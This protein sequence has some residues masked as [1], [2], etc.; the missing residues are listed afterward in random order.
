MFGL[1]VGRRGGG[2]RDRP[3]FRLRASQAMGPRHFELF[4]GAVVNAFTGIDDP[5]ESLESGRFGGE[6]VARSAGRG[7]LDIFYEEGVAGGLP[8]LGLDAARAAEAPLAGDERIDQEALLGVGGAVLL[9]VFGGKLGEI[10][11]F[12]VEHDLL[13]GV[14]AVLE[15]VKAGCGLTG[16]GAGSGR[17]LCVGAAG[18]ALFGSGLKHGRILDSTLAGVFG[19]AGNGRA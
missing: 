15:G 7:G 17:L 10:P 11:G 4:K 16:G 1:R 5:L 2:F 8:E 18:L 3:R 12:F 14:D 9:V 19:A 6:G 13:N